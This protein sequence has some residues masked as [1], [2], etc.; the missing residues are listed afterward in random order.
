MSL[1]VFKSKICIEAQE[2]RSVDLCSLISKFRILFPP[3][4]RQ[5]KSH[6]NANAYSAKQFKNEQVV[7][8]SLATPT[9]PRLRTILLA[10]RLVHIPRMPFQLN[11][12]Q[13]IV[14]FP[15]YCFMFLP[16]LLLLDLH[17][18]LLCGYRHS[19]LRLK[20][21]KWCNAR[22]SSS[23]KSCWLRCGSVSCHDGRLLCR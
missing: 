12:N 21:A 3:Q 2:G 22:S 20:Y 15:F 4:N 18:A 16:F 7:L 14:S 1:D 11:L 17:A 5:W 9:P 19:L 8:D 13:T 10:Q 23:L 6:D